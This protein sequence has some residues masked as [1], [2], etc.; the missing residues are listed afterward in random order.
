M[1]TTLTSKQRYWHDQLQQAQSFDGS[2]ASYAKHHSLDVKALYHYQS[3]LRQK[4]V[5]E[6]SAKF[7][8]VTHTTA[9]DSLSTSS[10]CYRITLRNGHQL[11]VPTDSQDFTTLLHSVNAL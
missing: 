5:I 1:E 8:R 11:E 2:L 3:V 4:G 10:Q 6:S 7:T 9:I